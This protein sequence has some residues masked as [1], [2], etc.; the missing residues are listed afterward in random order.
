VNESLPLGQAIRNQRRAFVL[1]GVL[2]FAGLWVAVGVGEWQVGIFVAAGV[3]LG[4]ANGVFTDAFLLRAT[5]SD[6]MLSRK[7]FAISSLV[8]LSAISLIALT[9]TIAFWPYG[10]AVLGG[11]AAFHLLALVLTALPLLKELRQA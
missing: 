3:A 10:G 1:A 4:L 2:A 5:E 7:Q 9:L 6:N 11:L 8:R